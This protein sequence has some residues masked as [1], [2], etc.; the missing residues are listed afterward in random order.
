MVKRYNWGVVLKEFSVS[1]L[2]LLHQKN[3]G[4]LKAC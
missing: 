2:V 3:M 4:K 1:D